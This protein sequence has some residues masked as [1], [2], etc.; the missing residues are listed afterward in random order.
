MS[1]AYALIIPH[2]LLRPSPRLLPGSG[3]FIAEIGYYA[4]KLAIEIWIAAFRLWKSIPEGAADAEAEVCMIC[5]RG[6]AS[7]RFKVANN[8]QSN[9]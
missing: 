1:R 6:K 4:A 7:G 8:L 9:S 3:V 5:S 2:L